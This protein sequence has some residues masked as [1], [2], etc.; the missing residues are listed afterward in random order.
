MPGET[1]VEEIIIWSQIPSAV[2]PVE[3]LALAKLA[4]GKNVLEL[5]A[6][7]GYSTVLLASVATHVTSVDWHRGDEHAGHCDSLEAYTQNLAKY[8]VTD[9]VTT[10]VGRF[11][12]EVPTLAEAGQQFDGAFLD[13]QHD[14]LSAT[15]DLALLLTVVKPGGFIAFH[16]YGRGPENGFPGFAITPVADD[17]GIEGSVGF[18]GWG[19]V[20]EDE[21]GDR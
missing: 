17:W 12:Q 16:D 18:L 20:P 2:T 10:I 6:H 21:P 1:S 7:Y 15:R 11:E 13:G 8:G 5:G 4:Y 9:K 14:I 19:F 3:S